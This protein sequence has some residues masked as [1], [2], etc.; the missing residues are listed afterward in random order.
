MVGANRPES[1]RVLLFTDTLGDVNGVS[2]FIRN[3]AA[4]A[5]ATGRDLRV[6]T[7]TR[8]ET[9][10]APN[11]R[12]FV[13]VFA[14]RMPG[15]GELEWAAPPMLAML[16]EAARF[17][18][19]VVHVSTPGPVGLVGAL[20]ARRLRAPVAGV[21][22][23]DFPAY[24]DHLFGDPSCTAATSWFMRRFYKPFS[25]LFTRSEEY[26][27]S[28]VRLGIERRR[29]VPLRAGIDTEAF[30]IRFADERVWERLTCLDGQRVSRGGVK[31]L[32]VGRVSVE[33]NL[34]MLTR[35][36][37]R[38]AQ[39]A[40]S[41]DV[42]ADELQLVVVGDGPYRARMQQELAAC[43]A[44]VRF[45]GFRHALEL[46]TI[47]ASADFFV[48]PSTTDTLGQVVMEAQS[49]GL[50]V[51]VTDVGGPKEVV[52]HGRTG[53]VLGA[54]DER[55]WAE[56]LLELARDRTAR[57][58]MGGAAHEKMKNHSIAASFEHYWA[59][60]ERVREEW[61]RNGRRRA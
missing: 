25:R 2:R 28:L 29:I 13:P 31:A 6:M 19:H 18:P 8:F 7:S 36:W 49:S 16:R 26:T 14:G 47:Y 37:K 61:A 10:V 9:P 54:E 12:S 22:H 46:S 56:R 35:V 32:Y 52:D 39:H 45:L 15:Y 5:A 42:P 23:T 21:Y 24:I 3:M 34:P 60:H 57:R 38:V 51:I 20:V 59:E 55:A 48:F 4:C 58:A 30:H 43:A 17:R 44:P 50:P 40:R 27:A 41:V 33:K 1:T 53:F 11:V